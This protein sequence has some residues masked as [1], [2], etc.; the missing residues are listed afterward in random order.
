MTLLP[1]FVVTETFDHLFVA[2]P[3]ANFL[4]R[5][6]SRPAG[7]QGPYIQLKQTLDKWWGADCNV[8]LRPLFNAV[9]IFIIWQI[10]KRRDVFR[11]GEKLSRFTMIREV[12]R[13]VHL[14]VVNRYPCERVMQSQNPTIIKTP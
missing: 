9:P 6:L 4:R 10:W 11:N 5:T 2:C 14:F 12:N 3:D 8:K 1:V 7:I 13:N